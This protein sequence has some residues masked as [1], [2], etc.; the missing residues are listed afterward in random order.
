MTVSGRERAVALPPS[1]IPVVRSGHSAR[2]SGSRHWYHHAKE[3]LAGPPFQEK[4][5]LRGIAG[6][7]LDR[8]DY[9]VAIPAR[10]EA[11]RLPYALSALANTMQCAS[12]KGAVIVVVNDTQDGSARLAFESL[13]RHD[14]AGL[15]V[16]VDFERPIR[17]AAHARRLALDLAARAAP[18]GCLLTTD[19]DTTV[20]P[21]WV[22]RCLSE[23]NSG[24][25]LVCEDVMLDEAELSV[26]PPQVRQAGDAERA[27]FEACRRLW[28]VWTGDTSAASFLRPSGASMAMRTD[29]YLSVG[30]LPVP[31]VGEDR[32]LCDAMMAERR[33]VRGLANFGTRTSARLS[34]RATGGCGTALAQRAAIADPPC[35]ERLKPIWHLREQS[36]RS[37]PL[38]GGESVADSL[39]PLRLSEVLRELAIAQ[40]LL[41]TYGIR[42]AA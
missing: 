19:A 6:D 42:D 20:G 8:L 21:D 32:A 4:A 37:G 16:A 3:I 24:F 34:G 27:Y 33:S 41:S 23:L 28:D 26:L 36:L 10:D 5:F 39:P 40:K 2:R 15:V 9:C 35:D 31:D 25:D 18:L 38:S 14:L 11:R 13:V 30:R 7:A 29:A 12:A 17:N 22:P 1:P